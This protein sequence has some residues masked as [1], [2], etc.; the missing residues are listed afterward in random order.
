MADSLRMAITLPLLHSAARDLLHGVGAAHGGEIF[1]EN[2]VD[3]GSRRA[4]RQRAARAPRREPGA[5]P[6]PAPPVPLPAGWNLEWQVLQ[7]PVRRPRKLSLLM[8]ATIA[9]IS[10]A[11]FLAFLSSA[12]YL[13]ATWQVSHSTPSD[14]EM[15][16]MAWRATDLAGVPFSC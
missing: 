15:N 6:I 3:R 4:R 10:R 2:V 8:A 16:C 12:S 1:I 13:P 5:H 9:I 14:T 11:V 7:V